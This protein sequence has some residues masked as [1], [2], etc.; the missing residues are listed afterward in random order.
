MLL[1]QDRISKIFIVKFEINII[2]INIKYSF[3][4]QSNWKMN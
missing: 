3:E 1:S 2:A 4:S